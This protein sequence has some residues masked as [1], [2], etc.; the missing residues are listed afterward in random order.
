MGVG[1]WRLLAQGSS[2]EDQAWEMETPHCPSDVVLAPPPPAAAAV[3]KSTRR[4]RAARY[5]HITGMGA[6]I[7]G[8]SPQISVPS[9]PK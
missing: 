6:T 3:Q 5:S 7:S 2:Q 4:A 9:K 1:G 8:A